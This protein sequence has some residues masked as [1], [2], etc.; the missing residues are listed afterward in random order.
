MTQLIGPITSN[1][2][3][4]L[5]TEIKK[6]ENKHK[7]MDYAIKPLLAE[8][9]KSCYPYAFI[10][11]FIQVLIIVLLIYIIVKMKKV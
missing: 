2:I 11:L 6:K 1:I 8:I 10:F 4:K 5:T 7:I 3:N 9:L